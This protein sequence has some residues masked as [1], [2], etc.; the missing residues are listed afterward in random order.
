MLSLYA[1]GYL[2]R[3][4][5]TAGLQF[6]AVMMMCIRI[7]QRFTRGRFVPTLAFWR[8]G[9]RAQVVKMLP[10]FSKISWAC[11]FAGDGAAIFFSGPYEAVEGN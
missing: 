8:N 11:V 9:A 2:A 5:V 3:R 1:D 4:L 7:I 10:A 6:S